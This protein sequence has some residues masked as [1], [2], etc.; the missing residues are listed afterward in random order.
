[1]KNKEDYLNLLNETVNYYTTEK[2]NRSIEKGG[3]FYYK[4]G[5]MCAVGRC[6]ID[7]KEVEENLIKIADDTDVHDLIK[8]Y[9]EDAFKH[10]YRGFDVLFW[11]LLQDLHDIGINWNGFELTA[12][13]T[14]KVD[15]IKDW[16]NKF[17]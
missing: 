10:Q 14:T 17:V 8:H 1:M 3:C 9:K 6:L 15:Y 2:N 5:N 4:D 13:G 11:S 12:L 7:P 16:V